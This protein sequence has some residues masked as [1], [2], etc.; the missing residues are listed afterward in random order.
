MINMRIALRMSTGKSKRKR[1]LY[2]Y[3]CEC[4]NV[5]IDFET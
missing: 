5:E 4:W 3:R 2:R 1:P